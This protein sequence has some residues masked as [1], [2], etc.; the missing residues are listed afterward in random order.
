MIAKKPSV[1]T[2]GERQRCLALADLV[3]SLHERGREPFSVLD[4]GPASR[5]NLEFFGRSGGRLT[6]ADLYRGFG[7]ERR[8]T[9]LLARLLRYEPADRFDLVLTWDLMNYLSPEELGGLVESLSAHLRSGTL[10]HALIVTAREMAPE[11]IWYRIEDEKTL[12]R[13]SNEGGTVHSPLY[14]EPELLRSMPGLT[15]EHCFQLR[16]GMAEY[17]FTY[18]PRPRPAAGLFPSEQSAAAE[19]LATRSRLERV[20]EWTPVPSR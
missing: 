1:P 12:V 5:D 18:R 8:S 3:P 15:V 14:V 7:R 2:S 9:A 6:V 19:A 4:L 13:V 11:P 17:V 20:I 16:N 10:V